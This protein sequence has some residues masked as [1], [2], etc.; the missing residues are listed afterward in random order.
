MLN[1][2]T[3]ELHNGANVEHYTAT[4]PEGAVALRDAFNGSECH[5]TFDKLSE[6]VWQI[7]T[8]YLGDVV[9]Y[10]PSREFLGMAY[11]TTPPEG[12]A[13]FDGVYMSLSDALFCAGY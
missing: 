7:H 1:T 5:W 8:G 6:T 13:V 9:P 3:L 4:S 12:M 11:L 10:A 2:I